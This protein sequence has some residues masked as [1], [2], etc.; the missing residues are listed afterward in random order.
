VSDYK[1]EYTSL[2]T[3][4]RVKKVPKFER[5]LQEMI[6]MEVFRLPKEEANALYKRHIE[7][8]TKRQENIAELG[9][10]IYSTVDFFNGEIDNRLDE[11]EDLK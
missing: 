7:A 1:L 11:I 5:A 6:Q 4:N 3:Y 10:Q 2:T 9:K 8:K